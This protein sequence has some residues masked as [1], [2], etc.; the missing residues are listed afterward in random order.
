MKGNAHVVDRLAAVDPSDV[1]IPPPVIAELA[2]GIERLPR[3]KRRASLQ[4]R[5]DL[6]CLEIGR[7]EW[8]DAVSQEF[9]RIKATLERRGARLEDFDAA[10]AAHATALGATLV[11][12]NVR[13]MKRIPGLLI[14]NWAAD[15]V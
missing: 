5:F 10:I 8:S 14:E 1:R 2:Y 6:I 7:A 15:A 12:A 4:A 3:S 13:H 11:T 9:G